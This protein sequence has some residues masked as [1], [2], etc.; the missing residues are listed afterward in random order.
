MNEV[1]DWNCLMEWSEE[2][3]AFRQLEINLNDEMR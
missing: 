1:N 2:S 3:N